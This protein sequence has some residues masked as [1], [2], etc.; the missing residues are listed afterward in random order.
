MCSESLAFN[1]TETCENAGFFGEILKNT[2]IPAKMQAFSAFSGV[3][4]HI[5]LKGCINAGISE[6]S[7]F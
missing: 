7:L 1:N 6:F 3:D 4:E 5:A 2:E